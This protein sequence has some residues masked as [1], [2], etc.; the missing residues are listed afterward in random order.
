VTHEQAEAIASSILD[1][2]SCSGDWLDGIIQAL[3]AAVAE[4]RE[5]CARLAEVRSFD[6][7]TVIRDAGVMQ[8]IAEA[9]RARGSPPAS[10]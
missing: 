8:E 3:L 2:N 1:G 6:G 7:A 5:A 10:A 4:E 9:I